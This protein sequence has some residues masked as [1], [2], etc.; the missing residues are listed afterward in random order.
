MCLCLAE[1][2]RFLR[3]GLTFWTAV[4]GAVVKDGLQAAA[5]AARS[6]V[7]ALST[8]LVTSNITGMP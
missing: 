2:G 6:V 7:S 3:P 1:R 5:Q 8:R 4:G